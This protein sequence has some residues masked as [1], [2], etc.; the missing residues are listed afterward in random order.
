MTP[1]QVK[2]VEEYTEITKT[3]IPTAAE[4]V[5]LVY[6][7]GWSIRY[8]SDGTA[9][10]RGDRTDPLCLSLAKMFKRE[11][12][13]SDVLAL[14]QQEKTNPAPEPPKP[15]E[16]KP[17]APAGYRPREWR[18]LH[19][20]RYSET[21]GDEWLYAQTDRHPAGAWWYRHAGESQWVPIQG[22]CD[23]QIGRASCRER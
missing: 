21:P 11:P 2:V 9:S 5:L 17:E 4:I 20:H 6:G 8:N 14:V 15:V 16:A 10:I 19:G 22:R 23:H 13:R 3:R 1:E 12:Y 7:M 18:W